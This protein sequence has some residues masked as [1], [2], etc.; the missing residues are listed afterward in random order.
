MKYLLDTNICVFYA[1]QYLFVS[2][3]D[4]TLQSKFVQYLSYILDKYKTII[5]CKQLKI[6]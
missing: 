5:I 2:K 6:R 3:K 1:L 4:V